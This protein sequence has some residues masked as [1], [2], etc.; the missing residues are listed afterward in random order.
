MMFYT[1]ST[2]MVILGRGGRGREVRSERGE[3]G[4]GREHRDREGERRGKRDDL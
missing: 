2:V 4:V 1:Q 3:G